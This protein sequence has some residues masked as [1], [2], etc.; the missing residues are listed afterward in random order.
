[1]P[2]GGSGIV[3]ETQVRADSVFL[4]AVASD[5]Y[6]MGSRFLRR[7]YFNGCVLTMLSG[8][9]KGKS[10]RIVDCRPTNPAASPSDGVMQLQL[11]AFASGGAIDISDPVR[12][13]LDLFSS[14]G[15]IPCLSSADTNDDGRVDISDA[16]YA[17]AAQ[18]LGGPPLP[19]PSE[20]GEDPT[21]DA[22][23]CAEF[24]PCGA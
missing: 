1:M 13:L 12:V 4:P 24:P 16:L 22:V 15:G 11:Q 14:P 19:E 6:N 2:P 10:T 5:P 23:G 18:F 9:L 7:G 8:P 17:L 3:F 21:P 20:C